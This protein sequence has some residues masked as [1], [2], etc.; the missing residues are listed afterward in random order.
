[1]GL[2]ISTKA[3]GTLFREDVTLNYKYPECM[4]NNQER[5]I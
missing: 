1:M 3:V 2:K 4:Y 5:N